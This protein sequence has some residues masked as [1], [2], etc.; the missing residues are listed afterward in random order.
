MKKSLN[1]AKSILDKFV[2]L[3]AEIVELGYGSLLTMEFG[4]LTPMELKTR[5]GIIKYKRGA[6]HLWVYMCAW[7]IEKNHTLIIGNCDS[8]E[9]IAETLKVLEGKRLIKY[10]ILDKALD[11]KFYFEDG[12]SIT[13]FDHSVEDTDSEHWMLFTPDKY[14]LTL[15]PGDKIGYEPASKK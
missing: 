6:W 9:R 7:R 8:R 14:V 13:L 5:R 10:E 12:L 2:G 15:G 3:K 4:K 11:T 1:F